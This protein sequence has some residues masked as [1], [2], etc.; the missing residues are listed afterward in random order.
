MIDPIIY[1]TIEQKNLLEKEMIRHV[2]PQE[3]LIHCL[4]VIDLSLAMKSQFHNK[5]TAT[6]DKIKWII[7][8]LKDDQ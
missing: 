6:D 3:S 4:N 2:S 7:L 8:S 5:A 1:V